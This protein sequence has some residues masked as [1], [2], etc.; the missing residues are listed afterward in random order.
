MYCTVCTCK[1]DDDVTCYSAQHWCWPWS[2]GSNVLHEDIDASSIPSNKFQFPR[3]VDHRKNVQL[4]VL[5]CL[6]AGSAIAIQAARWRHKTPTIIQTCTIT[7]EVVQ[8]MPAFSKQSYTHYISYQYLSSHL[9]GGNG[10]VEFHINV[11]FQPRTTWSGPGAV[12]AWRHQ[13]SLAYTRQPSS[14]S[15]LILLDQHLV[16]LLQK[17]HSWFSLMH[18]HTILACVTSWRH[19]TRRWGNTE[20]PTH[21]AASGHCYTW[22]S[23]SSCSCSP[24]GA[25]L[26]SSGGG[27]GGAGTVPPL[28]RACRDSTFI[29]LI[30]S[31]SFLSM[32]ALC[33]KQPRS[34]ATA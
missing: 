10:L 24:M 33:E 26:V 32:L 3:C 12:R 23:S 31:S 25:R 20:Q 15:R 8:A 30:S 1:Q 29:M 18:T 21:A 19:C 27:G 6:S 9:I 34:T 14:I 4:E 5:C 22:P 28:I 7:S 11:L 13:S 2:C 17:Y 16:M